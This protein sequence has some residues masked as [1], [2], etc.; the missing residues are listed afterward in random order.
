MEKKIDV[1]VGANSRKIDIT[2]S[3]NGRISLSSNVAKMLSLSANA[4]VDV[5]I[6]TEGGEYYLFRRLSADE[7]VGRHEGMCYS[8]NRKSPNIRSL[9]IYSKAITDTIFSAV[10]PPKG[11]N[12][13]RLWCGDPIAL[14]GI[15]SVAL[16]IIT[17]KYA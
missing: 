16:P 1:V 3:R 11:T 12:I 7:A 2:L 9:R 15:A 4:V 5:A 10:D 17:R 6:D 14:D 8:T 13:L